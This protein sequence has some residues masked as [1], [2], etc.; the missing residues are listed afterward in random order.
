L[1]KDEKKGYFTQSSPTISRID[2]KTAGV[3]RDGALVTL[4]EI[5]GEEKNG[6]DKTVGEFI[7]KHH[8]EDGRDVTELYE[9]MM[10]LRMRA[11]L[12]DYFSIKLS[13]IPI[14][15]QM[16]FLNFISEEP[17]SKI[18][19]VKKFI[20]GGGNNEAI[21]SR[22]ISFLSLRDGLKG[23]DLLS[24]GEYLEKNNADAVFSKYA[25]IVDASE[26]IAAYVEEYFGKDK[27]DELTPEILGEIRE[28]MLRRGKDLLVRFAERVE[29]REEIDSAALL[30]ELEDARFS[31]TAFLFSLKTLHEAGEPVRL[32]DIKN[33]SARVEDPA[34]ISDEDKDEMR[35][36]YRENYKKKPKKQKRLIGILEK[37]FTDGTNSFYMVR[38]EGK[39]LGFY[40]VENKGGNRRYAGSF[41]IDPQYHGV[42][43]GEMI[44]EQSFYEHINQ[45]EEIFGADCAV[46]DGVAFEYIENGFVGVGT[47]KFDEDISMNISANVKLNKAGTFETKN[48][49]TQEFVKQAR[50]GETVS[51]LGGK[52]LIS[53]E[54]FLS[55]KKLP[56]EHIGEIHDGSK[57]VLT[58]YF[59]TEDETGKRNA[60][61]VFELVKENVLAEY[62][63][64]ADERHERK[65]A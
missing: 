35:R 8:Y 53:T 1:S 32:E 21:A 22:L 57:Y 20:Y 37:S 45:G 51:L 36:M 46:F 24:L 64:E 34:D 23:D 55:R 52:I 19:Q 40:R 12:E 42:H 65:A 29:K 39:I 49:A 54:P 27:K 6:T 26:D 30:K 10:T 50:T 7:S 44:L 56:M 14:R 59:H 5:S 63:G 61:A 60:Y 4:F 13:G 2:H 31:N 38:N 41:N 11:F 43:L 3:Y 33:V 18:E 25:E 15:A 9:S 62:I 58:R 16:Y 48:M 17:E 47:K 28:K